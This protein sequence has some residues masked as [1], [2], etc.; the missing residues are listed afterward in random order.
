MRDRLGKVRAS[1]HE[2]ETLKPRVKVLWRLALNK[3]KP[4]LIREE[5]RAYSPTSR[6][7]ALTS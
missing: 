4:T 3:T 6:T 1:T 5:S 7:N 2:K